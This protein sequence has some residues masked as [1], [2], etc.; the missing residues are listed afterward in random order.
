MRSVGMWRLIS[1]WCQNEREKNK[2]FLLWIQATSLWWRIAWTETRQSMW[3]VWDQKWKMWL[4]WW[5][6]KQS[7]VPLSHSWRHQSVFTNQ[8]FSLQWGLAHFTLSNYKI[9]VS[10]ISRLNNTGVIFHLLH[11]YALT[12]HP[13]KPT[14]SEQASPGWFPTTELHFTL[15]W[16]VA[17]KHLASQVK[18]RWITLGTRWRKNTLFFIW[19]W[20]IY[21]NTMCW[22]RCFYWSVIISN[23]QVEERSYK[24]THGELPSVNIAVGFGI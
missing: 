18:D 17:T 21:N 6:N 12:P 9:T 22:E 20:H 16:P 5:L 11:R 13:H 24:E 8:F 14:E 7:I 23:L 2:P 4:S 3:S 10:Y 19:A 1:S 15:L